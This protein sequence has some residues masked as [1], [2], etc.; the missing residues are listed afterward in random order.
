[1]PRR[2]DLWE[3]SFIGAGGR[4]CR[5]TDCSPPTR[6]RLESATLISP[7]PTWFRTKLAGVISPPPAQR[8]YFLKFHQSTG[9]PAVAADAKT[10]RPATPRAARPHPLP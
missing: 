1:V 6:G 9:C 10:A 4:D 5:R 8:G 7:P 2:A 3:S